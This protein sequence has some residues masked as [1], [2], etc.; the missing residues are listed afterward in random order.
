MAFEPEK[1]QAPPSRLDDMQKVLYRREDTSAKLTRRD[2][3]PEHQTDVAR[4]WEQPKIADMNTH[5]VI[6]ARSSFWTRL[7][8]FSLA[9]FIVAAAFGAYVIFGGS[10]TVSSADVT[11]SVLGPV[12]VAAGDPLSLDIA[13]RNKNSATLE[14][15]ELI[16]EYPDGTKQVADP[17]A[18]LQRETIP[19][20]NVNSGDLLHESVKAV[21]FGQQNETKTIKFS[22]QYNIA[23]SSALFYTDS[24]YDVTISSSPVSL[25]VTSLK[26]ITAGQP[27][28]FTVDVTSGSASTIKGVLVHADYP[29]GFTPADFSPKPSYS[30]NLWQLGDLE[31]GGKRTIHVKGTLEGQDGQD[32]V[33]KFQTGTASPTDDK[34]IG[35]NFVD[36]QQT[37]SV[38]KPFIGIDIA[39]DGISASQYA[40]SAGK[41]IHAT[42]NWANNTS[43]NIDNGVITAKLNGDLFDKTSVQAQGGYYRSSD[44]TV[45]WDKTSVPQLE[46]MAAGA[47]GSVSFTFSTLPTSK[48]TGSVKN[49]QV[50]FDVSVSGKRLG[51]NSVPEAVN[52]VA[53]RTVKLSS[54]LSLI[55]RAV[56]STGPFKNAGPLPPK[57][58]TPTTYTVIWSITNTSNPIK[59]G[60]VIAKLPSYVTWQNSFAPQSENIAYDQT[61]RTVE[62]DPGDIA[63][64]A[65]VTGAAKEVAFQV[66]FL[67][68]I[69]QVGTAP[70]ILGEADL[71]GHD[72][73]SDADLDSSKP[74]L[75]TRILTDPAFSY[76][77]ENV[78]R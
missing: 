29:F 47:K 31:P 66:S 65:G 21:L 19:L 17:T 68:S 50:A 40:A 33:F 14:N 60:K 36:S 4:G 25:N 10:N 78:V 55:S 1:R 16:V 26:E 45:V 37:V 76:G 58:D 56:Y 35:T 34:T 43:Q 48:S 20:G 69:S 41:N 63:A 53:S 18:S 75:S 28:D 61:S 6:A 52:S 71:S 22:V 8:L 51:D 77:Q 42:I 9:F 64:D 15:A 12:S 73:W 46:H 44:N 62:W 3:L 2:R 30:T 24:P 74:G 32:L 70:A 27:I 49:P 72:T 13:V 57:T 67:P 11:V 38:T 7:F 5:E 59:E 54:A 39:L 23:G